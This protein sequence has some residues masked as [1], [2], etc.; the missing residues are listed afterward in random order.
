MTVSYLPYWKLP[1]RVYE[2]IIQKRCFCISYA[3]AICR[4]WFLTSTVGF[5]ERAFFLLHIGWP[6]MQCCLRPPDSPLLSWLLKCLPGERATGRG[7][8]NCILGS[9]C[10]DASGHIWNDGRWELCKVLLLCQRALLHSCSC[11]VQCMMQV[12][13][14]YGDF[15]KSHSVPVLNY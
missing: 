9:C 1:C 14:R 2:S 11:G 3:L 5:T 13:E 4:F 7:E 6:C 15:L 10:M 12:K 8:F